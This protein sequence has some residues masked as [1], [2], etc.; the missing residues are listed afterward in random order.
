[1]TYALIAGAIVLVA[2]GAAVAVGMAREGKDAGARCGVGFAALRGALPSGRRRER[3]PAPLVAHRARAATRP[4]CAA[5]PGG[6]DRRGP[7]GLGGGGARR[8]ALIHVQAFRVD[9]FE[10]T[11]GRWR[12]RRRGR[13]G[14]RRQRR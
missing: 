5:P 2:V 4:T 14:A 6:V 3:V 13:T 7:L 11:R 10:V 12:A 9:A 1:M 8:A